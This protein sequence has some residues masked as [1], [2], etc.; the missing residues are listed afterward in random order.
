MCLLYKILILFP[1]FSF[2]TYVYHHEVLEILEI[3]IAIFLSVN[4]NRY[5]YYFDAFHVNLSERIR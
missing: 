5:F 2:N 1:L 4:I 3:I